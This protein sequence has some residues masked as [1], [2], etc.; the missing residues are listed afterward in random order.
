MITYDECQDWCDHAEKGD[1]LVYHRG[2]LLA[3]RMA[4]DNRDGRIISV[5]IEPIDRIAKQMWQ[6]YRFGQVCLVQQKIA[7]FTYDYIAVKR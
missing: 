2:L 4:L 6:A 1:K 7:P 3:D 5:I